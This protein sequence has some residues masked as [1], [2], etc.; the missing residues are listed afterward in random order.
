ML[1]SFGHELKI[2]M[3]SGH[4]LI[5]LASYEEKRTEDLLRRVAGERKAKIAIWSETRGFHKDQVP[6]QP[7]SGGEA[8]ARIAA[9]KEKVVFIL[10]DFHHHLEDSFSIRAI[11]DI[12]P[13]LTSRGQVIVFLS[14]L[15]VIPV[16]LE[17]DI[18]IL[19][20]PLPDRADLS[21]ILAEALDSLRTEGHKI[22]VLS[23]E[24]KEG[25]IR[26]AL[27]LTALEA[28]RVFLRAFLEKPAFEKHDISLV[29]QQKRQIIRRQR[30]LEYFETREDLEEVGGLDLLKTWLLNRYKAFGEDARAYGLPEPKGLLLLGVQGCGKSLCAKA[31]SNLWKMPLLRLEISQVLASGQGP[32]ESN[33]R[34]AISLAESLSPCVLWIDE[35][36]KGFSS[37]LISGEK[38]HGGVA[39][40][41][42][43]FLTW[44]QERTLQVYVIATANS[45]SELPPELVRKGRFDEIFFVDLPRSHER[46][47]IFR[48]HLN[49]RN[50]DPENF[51]LEHLARASE[52]FSGSEIEQCIISAMYQAF[53]KGTEVTTEDILLSLSETVPLSETLEE[54]ITE[55]RRW[56][57]TR[58]RPASLDTKLIDLLHEKEK[59]ES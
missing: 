2:L 35:I 22:S 14:P 7:A 42:A 16:E 32:A 59:T 37:R 12:I 53:T 36:E 24:I 51:D 47:E 13:L 11:R 29:L 23:D 40:A 3:D 26:A 10:R 9:T 48:I 25:I 57:K 45:I 21:Q 17:K 31:V 43:S 4:V 30:F 33:L 28:R 44:M 8:L 52:G 54:K 5:Y 20:L 38:E 55:L 46:E 15:I 56:A 1:Q 27:G 6:G 49:K 34:G 19:D 41:F 58:A 39:R 50:R 18:T